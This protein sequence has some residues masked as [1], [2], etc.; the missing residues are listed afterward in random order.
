MSYSISAIKNL[1]LWE[2]LI[3]NIL[4]EKWLSELR[5]YTRLYVGFS[6]GLDSTV[7]L[8][9][10]TTSPSIASKTIAIHINH[11][12]SSKAQDWQHHCKMVCQKWNV[13]LI[14][15]KVSFNHDANIEERA[16]QARH[17]VFS[18]LIKTNEA[19]LLGHH[20]D[21]QAE[22]VLLQLFRGAGI[23][24]LSAMIDCQVFSQG[25]LLRP[26]LAYPR[27]VLES[28]AC[29]SGLSWVDDESNKDCRYSRNFLRQQVIPLIKT[30]WPGVDANLTRT[31]THCQQ[32]QMNLDELACLDHLR[33]KHHTNTLSLLPL[34]GLTTSRKKNILRVWLKRNTLCVPDTT[35][36]DRLIPEVI[37]AKEDSNP[38]L[39]WGN[40]YIRRYKQTLYL[41]EATNEGSLPTISWLNFPHLLMLPHHLGRL[42]ALSAS[43]GLVIPKGSRIDV[44]FRQGGERFYWHGQTKALKKL[45]QQW[46]IPPWLRNLIPL[47]YINQELAAV[48]GYAIGDRFYQSSTKH[49][50]HIEIY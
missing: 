14:T 46:H 13:P 44:C 37:E 30:R 20:Q 27:K 23:E 39:V 9:R 38:K 50:Y 7:L 1:W 49:S 19:L 3:S 5:H 47:I 26:L 6:G 43:Q 32:A 21:D 34:S 22:T 35:V 15:Q 41:L 16:R 31:A 8:H 11:G 42:K 45:F 4:N 24:G 28:Y 2:H 36:F 18:S 40:Y 33:L 12:L 48:V 10:L 17:A 29:S 25:W